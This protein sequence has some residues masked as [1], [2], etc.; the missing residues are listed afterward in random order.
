VLCYAHW[1]GFIKRGAELYLA[2]VSLQRLRC[3]DLHPCFVSLKF[4]Y[5]FGSERN[6]R[7]DRFVPLINMM[8]N[9]DH[10]YIPYKKAIDTESN[11]SSV[12]LRRITEYLNISYSG[13]EGD[14]NFINSRLVG[15][16]NKI[17]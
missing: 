7:L 15:V 5:S 16:R 14:E 9:N 8:R 2:H 11:L 4:S 6:R 3:E 12:V 10:P 17:A 13:F 1:E